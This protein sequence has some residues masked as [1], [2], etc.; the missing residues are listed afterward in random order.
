MAKRVKDYWP[1]DFERDMQQTLAWLFAR[2]NAPVGNWRANALATATVQPM[3]QCG[4]VSADDLSTFPQAAIENIV[5][6]VP[7]GVIEDSTAVGP[8]GF[9]INY[10]PTVL[11]SAGGQIFLNTFM[12]TATTTVSGRCLSLLSPAAQYRVDLFVRTDVWYYQGSAT[13]S[14]EGEGIATWSATVTFGGTPGAMI[15]V[16][17]PTSIAPPAAEWFGAT[18]PAGWRA[19]TNMGVGRKLVD[20]IGRVYSKTD[21]EYLQEDNLPV[22]VQDARH[23][24]VGSTAVMGAGTPTMHIITNDPVAGWVSVFSTLQHQAV[25]SDL[26]RSLDVPVSDP[27]FVP[28]V[29]INNSA[30]VQNRSW[31]YDAALAIIAYASAGNFAGARRI[32][33]QLNKFLD[34][35]EYLAATTLENCEDGSTAR[36]SVAGNPG[37]SITMWND[38]LREP[39]GGGKQMQCHAAAAGDAFTYIGPAVYGGGLPDSVDHIMQWQLRAASSLTWYFEAA[40][41]TEQNSVTKFRVTSDG[42]G[43]PAYDAPSKTITYPIG[44]GND[45]YHFHKFDLRELCADLAGDAWASTTGFKVVLTQAGD[46]HLDNL[47]LGQLQPQ[48][49]LSFSYDVYNGLPDQVYIR[50]GAMAWVAY[51]Y[52]FYMEATADPTPALYLEKMLGFLLTLESADADLRNGLL[53]GGYGRYLDPGYH[54]EPGLREWVSTEHNID[55]WFA[56]RRAA[57]VLPSA[58]SELQKRGLIT[59]AQAT[60]LGATAATVSSKADN[61]QTKILS[62]LYIAPGGDPGHFA[63]GVNA[64]GTLDTAV[65]LDAAGSW[66]AIFCHEAGDDTKATE[67]LKFIHQKLFLTNK[68]I[69]KSAQSADWNMAYDQ[70]TP[71]DG[72]TVYGAGYTDPPQAVW[73]EGTWGVIAALVRCQEV[74][75]VQSYFTTAEGSLDQFLSRLIRSQKTVLNT[76]KNGSLLNYSLASRSLPY[77]FSVWAGLGSTA[78]MWLTAWN[79]TTLLASETSWEWRPYLKVPQGVHQSIRQL[80]GQGSIGALELEAVDVGGYMTSLASGGKLEGRQVALKVGYPGM[81]SSDFVTV[82]TQEIESVNALPDLTGYILECRDLK[83]SAKSKIFTRGDDGYPI[84]NEHPRTLLA[85]PMDV[86]L[87][88]FQNELGLGQVPALPESAWTLYDPAQWDAAFGEN[89]TLLRPNSLVD[90]EQFLFYRHGIFSGY[91]MDFTF[92]QAVEAKQ[93]LEHEIFRAL[94]GYLVVLADGRLSPRFFF[95]PTSLGRLATFSDRNITVLPGVARHPIINQVTFRMDYDGSKFQTELL[96]VDAPSLQQF[97]LAGQHIIESKGMKLARGGASLAGL[98][99]TRIFRRYAGFDP[100][101]GTA[102][103]GATLLTVRSHY[104]TLAV[105]VGDFVFLS[106]PLLPNFETGQRGVAHRICEVLDKQPNFAEGAM[107]YRLLDMGWVAAKQLSLIAPQGTPAYPS[108]SGTERARYMFV[109]DD[110]TGTYSDGTAGKTIW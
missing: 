95:P 16:L 71:F 29:T 28:D 72:F 47:S 36:W 90:V 92:R 35:P 89:P 6:D 80:E 82:A 94:G 17:Y 68:T 8:D 108:A 81:S 57:R 85:N 102:N 110:A 93:F 43:L 46:L 100:A 97:G 22:I 21:I 24:R 7:T 106:H 74:A 103:G 11:P 38:P 69:V 63:Q 98:T 50:T 15:A 34:N 26:P 73:G 84:S 107:T 20:Y 27:A 99:A 67:C 10:S 96:F 109:S 18:L 4:I 83:R 25:F 19:H 86:A 40:L 51:A 55:A 30:A 77:E 9:P 58:A 44:P 91:L 2:Q 41:T 42:P 49:S 53:K 61:I 13:L 105:E 48:G 5:F 32:I 87:M 60:S 62:N 31:I 3:W 88:I 59:S 45:D 39:F 65:A 78:W 56:F 37:A 79:P 70:L 1:G 14:G 23:A 101:S 104:M 54:F 75:A 64:D 66:A 33:T 52:A 12:L 76:T